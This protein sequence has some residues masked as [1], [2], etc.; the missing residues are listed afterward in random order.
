VAFRFL[1]IVGAGLAVVGAIGHTIGW[2]LLSTTLGPTAYVF[3]AHPKSASAKRRNAILGHTSAV[4]AALFCLAVFGLWHH[5]PVTK[6]GHLTWPQVGAAALAGALT[7]ALL[8]L[9]DAHHAPAG[10]TALLIASG[11]AKPGPPLY[12]LLIGLALLIAFGPL[13]SRWFPL[14]RQGAAQEP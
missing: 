12:G 8:E 4:A 3:A 13:L 1:L 9:L 11:I 5:P 2:T 10:A 6:L 7:V 14:G